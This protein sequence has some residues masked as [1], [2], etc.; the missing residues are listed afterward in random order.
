M[1]ETPSNKEDIIKM[2]GTN[3]TGVPKVC[4]DT[5]LRMMRELKEIRENIKALEEQKKYIENCIAAHMLNHEV[6]CDEEGT[7]RVTWKYDKSKGF[8]AQDF[9]RDHPDL[10]QKYCTVETRRMLFK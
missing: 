6:L 7:I 5:H 3:L 1:I 8:C 10:Y 2:Y 4:Q 9:K